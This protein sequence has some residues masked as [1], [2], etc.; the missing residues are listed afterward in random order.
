MFG[1]I[2]SAVKYCHNL[3]IIHGDIKP[4]NVLIDE[5]GNM[6]L[7]D[8]GL[9]IKISPGTLLVQRRGTKNFWAPELMLGEPYDGRKTD[10]W[11]L[12][13]LLYFIT[14]GYYPFSGI[15]FQVIKSKVTTGTYRI[16]SYFSAQL[17]NLIY[18]ILI[19]P[20]EKRPYIEDIERHSRNII[21]LSQLIEITF[22]SH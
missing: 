14:T 1:Q 5:K 3:D 12:G 13:V 4:D 15:T 18:Q 21:H 6:K 22:K 11:S 2:V 8:F 20:P 10:V 19:V 9:A 7:T 17:E 16:P